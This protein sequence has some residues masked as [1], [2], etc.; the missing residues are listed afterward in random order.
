MYAPP[1]DFTVYNPGFCV[2][3]GGYPW[4]GWNEHNGVDEGHRKVTK[5]DTNDGTWSTATDFPYTLYTGTVR[6]GE[7]GLIPLT[8]QRVY[9]IRARTGVAM[10][11]NL[12]D[13]SSWGSE[14]TFGD[15]QTSTTFSAVNEGD[16]VHLVYLEDVSDDVTYLKRTYG[17]GWGSPVNV[18]SSVTV[19][20]APVLTIDVASKVLYCFWGGSPTADHIYYKKCKAGQWDADPTDW[21][22]ETTD[23]LTA[24]D[25]LT[26]Y[27]Q[28]HGSYIGLIYMTKTADPY[29]VRFDFLTLPLIYELAENLSVLSV[30]FIR[31]ISYLRRQ[32]PQQI[33]IRTVFKRVVGF[34]KKLV[35]NL[36][37]IS[38]VFMR[39]VALVRRHVQT[40]AVRDLFRRIQ[41][42]TR[43][44]TQL[45]YV[46]AKSSYV[47]V[48]V[49]RFVQTIVISDRFR[50][51]VSL[52]R[53]FR[54]DLSVLRA[55]FS[56]IPVH[57]VMVYRFVQNLSVIGD[58][59]TSKVTISI[60]AIRAKLT[61]VQAEIA[62][63]YEKVKKKAQF[64]LG[65]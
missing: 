52:I 44:L 23:D 32:L 6:Y 12:W 3:D 4:I 36:S 24:N 8:S 20:S 35:Q 48:K 53:R 45:I 33:V 60:E 62:D 64:Y 22:D 28:K 26:S 2:D 55:K 56:F 29:N 38:S 30:R 46:Q 19:T 31:K 15:I 16:D 40:V 63:L 41:T 54:L 7:V 51:R 65:K 14:E 9:A 39:R 21:I 17:V 43:R 34:P 50:R 10:M 18:Q 37:V 25:R 59:F 11:G 42:L 1:T 49:Y 5:S 27:Y 61:Q 13:G 47:L 57:V 58:V